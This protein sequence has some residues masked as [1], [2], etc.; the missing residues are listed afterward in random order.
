[1]GASSQMIASNR[2]SGF[3]LLELLL[4]VA[5]LAVVAVI[6]APPAGAWLD[7]MAFRDSAKRLAAALR[8][9]RLDA[10]RRGVIMEINL[11]PKRTG[12]LVGRQ[13]LEIQGGGIVSYLGSAT[14]IE[15]GK[16]SSI[17]LYP[18]GSADRGLVILKANSANAHVSIHPVTG[19]VEI[20]WR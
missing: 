19:R 17:V 8:L 10:M 6:V 5:L 2:K 1:M 9:A 11:A 7:K 13:R 3:T 4:V 16:E 15:V 20:D 12:V 14:G 18:D